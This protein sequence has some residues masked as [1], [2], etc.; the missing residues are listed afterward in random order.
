MGGVGKFD[1]GIVVGKVDGGC[2]TCLFVMAKEVERGHSDREV[3]YI[4][5]FFFCFG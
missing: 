1:G 3:I 4:I 5:N 2:G